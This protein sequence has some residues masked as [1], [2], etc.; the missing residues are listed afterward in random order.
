[1]LSV[2]SREQMDDFSLNQVNSLLNYVSGVTVEQV[3]TDRTYY[4]ARGIEIIIF[5][6]DGVGNPFSRGL[7]NSS[8]IFNYMCE[9]HTDGLQVSVPFSASR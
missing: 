2:V 5:Q 6:K 4:A 3:K 1:M 7:T 8:V 9:R